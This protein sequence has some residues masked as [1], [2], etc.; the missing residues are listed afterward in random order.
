MYSRQYNPTGYYLGKNLVSELD[1]S[2]RGIP[3]FPSI[4]V[5]DHTNA[6]IMV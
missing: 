6:Q 3:A 1:V 2:Q 5:I 4:I